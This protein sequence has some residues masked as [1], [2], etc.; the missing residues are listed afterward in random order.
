MFEALVRSLFTRRRKMLVNAL[1]PFAA[2]RHVEAPEILDATGLDPRRRPETLGLA[3]L[4]R[5]ADVF[6]S[7]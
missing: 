4:A 6:A 5:L 3:D 2:A 1:V 7:G